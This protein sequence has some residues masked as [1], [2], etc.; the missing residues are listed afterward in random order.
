MGWDG[1][2]WDGMGRDGMGWDY[3]YFRVQLVRIHI[4][5]LNTQ[6]TVICRSFM[7]SNDEIHNTVV[8]PTEL[9]PT[10]DY[11]LTHN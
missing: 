6:G 5:T 8:K 1:M 4:C 2:G 9:R 11:E 7:T 10:T 3:I